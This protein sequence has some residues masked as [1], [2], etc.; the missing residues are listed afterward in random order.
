M[1][2]EYIL[3]IVVVLFLGFFNN[4]DCL[5]K[6]MKK[7][8]QI[9]YLNGPSSV[10]KSTLARALQNRLQQPFLVIGIDQ[11]IYMMPEKLNDWHTGKNAQ[12]FSWQPVMDNQENVVSYRIQTGPY[13]EK[14]VQAFKDVVVALARSGNNIIID[15]VSFGKEQVDAWRATLQ[16]FNVLWI[17]VTAPLDIIEKREKE[18]GDRKLGSARWQ[19]ERVHADVDYDI[20]IDTHHKDLAKNVDI[21]LTF[22]GE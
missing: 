19:V 10:G 20:M 9:I 1:K 3:G 2:I 22:L 7:Q 8:Y 15:D 17:G 16:E 21:I 14:M 12:G 13:G 11:I 4:T 5:E 6:S 18:R